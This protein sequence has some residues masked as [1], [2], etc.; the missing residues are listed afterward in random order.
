MNFKEF[1]LTQEAVDAEGK[2]I[3][4]IE[5]PQPSNDAKAFF[6]NNGYGY[7]ITFSPYDSS[8]FFKNRQ[9]QG[10]SVSFDAIRDELGQPMSAD[11][12]QATQQ[13]DNPVIRRPQ[14]KKGT[15]QSQPAGG[16]YK[17]TS[18]GGGSGV[19]GSVAAAMQQFFKALK[20]EVLSW[21]PIDADLGRVY[22]VVTNKFAKGTYTMVKPV[23]TPLGDTL[24]RNDLLGNL[25]QNSI[26]V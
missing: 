14:S 12:I 6:V 5:P 9:S 7:Y 25:A 24:I 18:A 8:I 17:R 26:R 10:Y 1:L 23:Y 15:Y 19:L 11:Q 13:F 16:G 22:K 3:K 4:W 20:P 21:K 2:E